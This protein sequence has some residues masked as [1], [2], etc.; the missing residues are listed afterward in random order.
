MEHVEKLMTAAIMSFFTWVSL[1]ILLYCYNRAI[2]NV[3]YIIYAIYIDINPAI[4]G[5]EWAK[6]PKF[7]I[8]DIISSFNCFDNSMLTKVWIC[9]SYF[10]ILSCCSFNCKYLRFQQALRSNCFWKKSICSWNLHNQFLRFIFS[11]HI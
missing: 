3:I 10:S 6:R 1:A 5:Y 2:Y 7:F 9:F 4:A 11:F 8:A